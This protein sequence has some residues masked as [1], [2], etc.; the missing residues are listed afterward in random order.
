MDALPIE[1]SILSGGGLFINQLLEASEV[2]RAVMGDNPRI[3]PVAS[4]EEEAFPC[5]SYRRE[6]IN[7]TGVKGEEPPMEG[8]WEVTCWSRDYVESLYMAEAV[9]MALHGK[10]ARLDCGLT[11]RHCAL[12]SSTET[13]YENGVYAQEMIFMIRIN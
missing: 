10:R 13:A 2:L 11:I 12:V 5:I 9:R 7:T 4:M 6:D 1:L 8:T 3:F